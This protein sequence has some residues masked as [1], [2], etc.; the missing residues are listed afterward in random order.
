MKNNKIIIVLN[1]IM[2]LIVT[3]LSTYAYHKQKSYSNQKI[4]INNSPVDNTKNSKIT[5]I[6]NSSTNFK[7]ENDLSKKFE[8]FKKLINDKNEILDS[9]DDEI[10]SKY[11]DTISQMK[12][13]LKS[14]IKNT[15]KENTLDSQA[16]SDAQKVE[17]SKN[18]LEELKSFVT[19]NAIDIYENEEQSNE[20][21]VEIDTALNNNVV[22]QPVIQQSQN[23]NYT[24]EVQPQTYQSNQQQ[25]TNRSQSTTTR[26]TTRSR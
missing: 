25:A 10:S 18:K 20:I 9:K 14:S 21:I 13:E 17:S 3:G 2:L 19:K 1:V 11:N 26:R 24:Q 4:E 16:L 8:V 23:Y 12:E 15:I 5:L 22:S 6:T 7:N